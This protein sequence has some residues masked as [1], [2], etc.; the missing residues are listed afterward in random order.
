MTHEES[1]IKVIEDGIEY[2]VHLCL[3]VKKLNDFLKDDVYLGDC[4]NSCL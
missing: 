4:W 3:Y 1:N 2:D